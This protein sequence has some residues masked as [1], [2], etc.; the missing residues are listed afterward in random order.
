MSV[1][2]TLY[3]ATV[4]GMRKLSSARM[5]LPDVDMKTDLVRA[6]V[7]SN[8]ELAP[9][10]RR[11]TL[12]APEFASVTLTGADEYVGLLM[13]R[14][15][16]LT[17]PDPTIANIRAA[18]KEIP[19]ENR[20]YLRWYTIRELRRDTAE[21][22]ID[23]VT[24]GDSGP[25]SIWAAAAE[26]D[27]DVG[28]RFIGAS[29]YPHQGP[30]LYVADPTAMPALRAILANMDAD[31]RSKT[32]VIC[33]SHSDDLLEP[34]DLPDVAS[35]TRI[36]AAPATAPSALTDVFASP[37]C[38]VDSLTYAWLCGESSIA[39]TARRL[40][41]KQGMDKKKIF[42]SGYWKLGVERA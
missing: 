19:E 1:R 37:Q 11:L 8:Q 30:Q 31:T 36:D 14:Q 25:G 9:Q 23:I 12:T 32:H 29:H 24:H 5:D 15:G 26:L 6:R 2:N 16:K 13:P 34:G 35:F 10:L 17:M 38:D 4:K 41:V 27:S 7:V 18:V 39:T 22:D 42:F 40:L 21:V 3:H 33:V 20:P 28:V